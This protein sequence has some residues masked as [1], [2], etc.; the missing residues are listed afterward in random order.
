MDFHA[1][2]SRLVGLHL[3]GELNRNTPQANRQAIREYIAR[4]DYWTFGA[5]LDELSDLDYDE[6]AT[7]MASALGMTDERFAS[8]DQP[9]IDPDVTAGGILELRHR[10]EVAAK[11]GQRVLFATNHP[12]SML[13][14]YQVMA[15]HFEALGGK[16]ITLT[17]PLVAPDSRWLDQVG[18]V[19][20][21]SDE[22]NLM[23]AHV[24]N[25]FIDCVK[26]NDPDIVVAD[27]GFAM[28]AMNAGKNVIAIFDVDDPALPIVASRTPERVFAFPMNDNQ[29]NIRTTAAAVACWQVDPADV[30]S[31]LR[32]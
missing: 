8:N 17:E 13:G 20:M 12:G 24:G 9:Y 5:D 19:V 1:F 4:N 29:T 28:D 32:G 10:L 6:L 27:H 26:A 31:G 14:F 15:S 22:G 2:S 16:L 23:H 11:A 18:G 7:I 30:K 3:T 21:L 25:G